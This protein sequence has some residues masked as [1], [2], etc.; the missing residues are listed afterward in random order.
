MR[1]EELHR[2]ILGEFARLG[3]VVDDESS[4]HDDEERDTYLV[5]D[6]MFLPPW[7]ERLADGRLG[8]EYGPPTPGH[9]AEATAQYEFSVAGG[10]FWDFGRDRHKPRPLPDM[11]RL[12]EY[13]T[14][15]V[16]LKRFG[17]TLPARE[18]EVGT[19]WTHT[20][21]KAAG[22]AS[23]TGLPRKEVEALLA[24]FLRRWSEANRSPRSAA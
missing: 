7:R 6:L 18:L 13:I 14:A 11:A 24:S 5:R 22:M 21:L 15:E 4:P 12:G 17:H 9:L 10:G 20:K 2:E 3:V 1:T 8:P 23:R 16:F 19:L